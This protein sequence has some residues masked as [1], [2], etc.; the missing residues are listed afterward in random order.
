MDFTHELQEALAA[1]TAAGRY[2]QAEYAAFEPIPNAPAHI[3]THADRESQEII[4][5]H[6]HAAFPTDG[7]VAEEKTPTLATAPIHSQRQWVIDPIDGTRGFAM[8]NGEFSVMIGLTV[9]GRPVVGVVLEPAKNRLT[10]A[11]SGSGCWKKDGNSEAI[12]CR[13]TPCDMLSAAVLTQSHSK[14]GKPK[15]VQVK[16]AP[17]RVIETYSAGI[18]MA[19]VARGEADL[20][21]NDYPEFHDWDICAGEVLVVEAGGTVTE[22]TGEAVRYGLAGAKRRSGL[23]ASNGRLHD[24]AVQRL[25]CEPRV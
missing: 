8:K 2:L 10:Y 17:S 4:L 23:V 6:L 22:Y 3:S 1:A 13:V 15:P 12:R 7:L 9:N 16:L 20:Y 25:T 5:K 21:V 14:P 24:E 11:A 19:L 18:K